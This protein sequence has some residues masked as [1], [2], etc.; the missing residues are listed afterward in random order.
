MKKSMVLALATLSLA[1]MSCAQ[2]NKKENNNKKQETIE[3]KKVKKMKVIEMNE[4]MF[5]EKIV[6][7]KKNGGKWDYRGD[8]PAIID[9]YATWCGPCKATAP[10]LEELA[11]EYEGQIDVYK[12]DV[13]KNEELSAL[14]SIQSIPTLLFIPKNGQP[15]IAVGAQPRAEIERGI[16]ELLLK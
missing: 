3:T 9:F 2:A 5:S 11:A 12:V 8:K 1:M 6:D 16:K 15:T 4:A 10:I 14:F 7:Y 13:D